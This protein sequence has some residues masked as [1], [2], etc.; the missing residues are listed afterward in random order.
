MGGGGAGRR[1]G[2]GRGV[3]MIVTWGPN[4][5]NGGVF[6]LLGEVGADESDSSSP[7]PC[8]RVLDIP[9]NAVN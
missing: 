2:V 7:H 9:C 5:M 6:K 3:H 1:E 8:L 4:F